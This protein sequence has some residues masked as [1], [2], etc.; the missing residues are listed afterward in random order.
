MNRSANERTHVAYLVLAEAVENVDGKLNMTGGGWD[1][2]FVMDVERP[3]AFSFACG[4][5]V[6]WTEADEKHTLTLS[7]TG[8]DGHAIAPPH[9]ET[10][11]VG[12]ARLAGPQATAHLPFAIRWDL[13][14][15]TYGRFELTAVVDLRVDDARR[16]AFFVQP[17]AEPE[18]F[19]SEAEMNIIDEEL[20]NEL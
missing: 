17:P 16:V 20:A 18:P 11:R 1:T 8:P 10:F 7:V 9:E 13:T 3:V 14:F 2:L 4:V 12:R 15:P 19:I 5:Q 6:P